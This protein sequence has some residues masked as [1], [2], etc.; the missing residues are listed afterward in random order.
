MLLNPQYG[1]SGELSRASFV[2]Q[3]D[4]VLHGSRRRNNCC[5]DHLYG[6]RRNWGSY[7][8]RTSKF[9]KIPDNSRD[10]P[11]GSPCR[12]VPRTTHASPENP[13]FGERHS[14]TTAGKTASRF[15]SYFSAGT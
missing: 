11:T 15:A 7:I 9:Q 1:C 4:H 3:M 8:G 5:K 2:N 13:C 12:K 10:N 6:N 14:R